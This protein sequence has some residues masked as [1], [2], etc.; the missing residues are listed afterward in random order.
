M[1]VDVGDRVEF[2]TDTKDADY[3]IRGYVKTAPD[4]E[5]RVMVDWDDDRVTSCRTSVLEKV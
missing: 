5:G 1:N 4:E 2:I 3:G